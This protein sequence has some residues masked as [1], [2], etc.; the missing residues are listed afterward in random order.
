VECLFWPPR[1]APPIHS[2][3]SHLRATTAYH[4]AGDKT[5]VRRL[6]RIEGRAGMRASSNVKR[7]AS[8]QSLRAAQEAAEAATGR[9]D[10]A[11]AAVAAGA[12]AGAGARAADSSFYRAGGAPTGSGSTAVVPLA[13]GS[14]AR[15]ED[16]GRRWYE[17]LRDERYKEGWDDDSWQELPLVEPLFGDVLPVGNFR[18][19]NGDGSL[20]SA[21]M[22]SVHREFLHARR[23]RVT[24]SP[25]PRLRRQ[26]VHVE[27]DSRCECARRRGTHARS[28]EPP[29]SP[30]P[31]SPSPSPSSSRLHP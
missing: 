20:Q 25:H 26:V 6:S 8:S 11:A 2:P 12:A 19:L 22:D 17:L 21:F 27:H 15:P 10:L 31:P 14:A 30:P 24:F 23:K 5:S 9:R 4:H 3:R 13:A 28:Y 7:A 29:S 18:S 16:D 1:A